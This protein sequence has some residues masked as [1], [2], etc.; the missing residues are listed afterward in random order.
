MRRRREL[1]VLAFVL[2]IASAGAASGDGGPSPGA[3]TGWDGV[4]G[5]R[6]AVR[7]VALPRA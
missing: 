1:A 4:L 6:G 2:L 3:V 5:A 7:Y